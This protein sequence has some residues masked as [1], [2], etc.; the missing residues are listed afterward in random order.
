MAGAEVNSAKYVMI[1]SPALTEGG[2]GMP[3][4]AR[5]KALFY[6]WGY[7]P[8]E[9][10]CFHTSDV[11]QLQEKQ[12]AAGLFLLPSTRKSA[13][14]GKSTG[15]DPESCLNT[16]DALYTIHQQTILADSSEI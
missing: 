12:Q 5:L 14:I 11:S 2:Y 10:V 3:G 4:T 6:C 13:L 1:K 16:L 8:E 15:P 9:S 7:L